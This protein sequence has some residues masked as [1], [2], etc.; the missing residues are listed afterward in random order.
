ML[1]D[2]IIKKAEEWESCSG[3]T[4]EPKKT[5]FIHFTRN[6]MRKCD[7]LLLIRGETVKPVEKVKILGVTLDSSLRLKQSIVNASNKGLR[8]VLALKRLKNL[9]PSVSRQLFVSTVCPVVDYASVLWGQQV[10]ANL[11][12][13][14]AKIQRLG[15][16]S[17]TGAFKS[18]A[19]TILESEAG[20][21]HWTKRHKTQ[22]MQFWIDRQTLPVTN[23]LARISTKMFSRFVSP[24]QKIAQDYSHLELSYCEVIRPYY[25]PPWHSSPFVEIAQ[26]AEAA[27]KKAE[28]LQGLV[29]VINTT[30]QQGILGAGGAI[31]SPP[32]A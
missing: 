24:L 12:P 16:Q 13:G 28:A 15:A 14:L 21:F 11:R 19:L 8:A 32:Y 7:L 31:F 17:V 18:V 6:S 4:F 2:N 29:E 23:P 22:E 27:R 30:C 10:T 3:A 20:I 5:F 9:P 26:K 25:V 1:Q